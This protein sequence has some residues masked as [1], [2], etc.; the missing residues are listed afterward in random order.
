M[1][2][3][4]YKQLDRKDCAYNSFLTLED[5]MTSIT[6]S[7][8]SLNES[9]EALNDSDC[10]TDLIESLKSIK[11]SLIREQDN[12]EIAIEQLRDYLDS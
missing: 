9:I 12:I 11:T 8:E 2:W 10:N 3:N 4:Q 7:L 5:T 6:E 1:N